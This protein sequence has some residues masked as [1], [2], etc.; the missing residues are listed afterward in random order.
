MQKIIARAGRLARVL[1]LLALPALALFFALS[2][3]AQVITLGGATIQADDACFTGGQIFTTVPIMPPGTA[4]IIRYGAQFSCT[5]PIGGTGVPWLVTFH[6]V[7]PCVAG[8][9]C[10]ITVTKGQRLFDVTINDTPALADLDIFADVGSLTWLQRSVL[11]WPSSANALRINFTSSVRTAV[12]SSIDYNTVA[13]PQMWQ[14]NV[15]G[16]LPTPAWYGTAGT[17]WYVNANRVIR[18]FG[19]SPDWSASDWYVTAAGR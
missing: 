11:V 5:I 7:E 3:P 17:D 12:V 6:F 4:G 13:L 9:G 10:S 18:W 14:N 1:L 16:L 15:A 2:I 8:G 19:N